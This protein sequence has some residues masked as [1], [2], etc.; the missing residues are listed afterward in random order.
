[1]VPLFADRRR[2][3]A[4][5]AVR[6]D[7]QFHAPAAARGRRRAAR[8]ARPAHALRGLPL[9]ACA[10]AR[11]GS[12][13]SLPDDFWS[14]AVF[15][16]RGRNVYSLNDR[17]AERADARSRGHHAGADGAAPAGSAGVAGDRDRRRA[18]DRR[19]LR[20]AARVRRRRYVLAERGQGARVPP[21]APGRSDRGC[22][23]RLA[24]TRSAAD[25][26][27]VVAAGRVAQ[28]DGRDRRSCRS[29]RTP[30]KMTISQSPRAVADAACGGRRRSACE[31]QES[32]PCDALERSDRPLSMPRPRGE[33]VLTTWR[34]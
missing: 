15:D 34:N 20:A 30:G 18:A 28:R 16:R 32:C 17:S 23:G 4:D 26:V 8:L 33:R 2:V 10:T 9:L 19:R 24:R 12:R 7:G 14:V 6:R 5:A 21:T 29:M 25:V 1:M 11:C 27:E 13:A 22:S 31:A 3:G